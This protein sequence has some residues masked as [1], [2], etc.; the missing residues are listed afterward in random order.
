MNRFRGP[1]RGLS[2]C[3]TLAAA[4]AAQAQALASPSDGWDN[5]YYQILAES[6]RRSGRGQWVYTSDGHAIGRI[7]DVRTSPDGMHELAVVDVRSLMGG[8][9]IAVPFHR[10]ARRRDRIVSTDDRA[11][12]LTMQRLDVPARSAR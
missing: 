12:V 8:G 1:G 3:L 4:T 7:A 9:V 11:A 2:A 5:A 10:L 6:L